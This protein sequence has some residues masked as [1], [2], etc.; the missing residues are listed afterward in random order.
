VGTTGIVS[1]GRVLQGDEANLNPRTGSYVVFNVNTNFRVTEKIE[2]FGLVQ[3][4]SNTKYAT[5]GG[6]SPVQL[7]PM[8]QAPGA[9]YTRSLTPG[10]PIAGYGG[11]RVTF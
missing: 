4:I 9:T 8:L 6:F 3:N 5:F 11:V 1:S 2:L 10:P 7:V